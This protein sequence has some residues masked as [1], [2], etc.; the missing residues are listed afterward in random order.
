MMNDM[1]WEEDEDLDLDSFEEDEN[2]NGAPSSAIQIGQGLLFGGLSRLMEAVTQPDSSSLG[3]EEEDASEDGWNDD[4]LDE[5]V[6]DDDDGNDDVLIDGDSAVQEEEPARQPPIIQQQQQQ[7]IGGWD[8]DDGLDGL[9]E[10]SLHEESQIHTEEGWND[11]NDVLEGLEDSPVQEPHIVNPENIPAATVPSVAAAVPSPPPQDDSGGWDNDDESLEGLDDSLPV[12]DSAETGDE[13]AEGGWD[14]DALLEGLDDSPEKGPPLSPS[15]N[16]DDEGWGNDEDDLDALHDFQAVVDHVPTPPRTPSRRTESIMTNADESTVLRENARDDEEF[17]PSDADYGPIVD[18]LPTSEHAVAGTAAPSEMSLV[19]ESCVDTLQED[20][21]ENNAAKSSE[22]AANEVVDHV[23]EDLSNA[24]TSKDTDSTASVDGDEPSEMPMQETA[25][26]GNSTGTIG[27]SFG[28]V[29]D[30]MPSEQHFSHV[31][32]EHTTS[33]NVP[34]SLNESLEEESNIQEKEV[35]HVPDDILD[36]AEENDDSTASV[37]GDDTCDAREE[38]QRLEQ[39]RAFQRKILEVDHVPDDVSNVSFGNENS[40]ASVDGDAPSEFPDRT[41]STMAPSTING[42]LSVDLN[43]IKGDNAAQAV[44][45]GRRY[46]GLVDHVPEDSSKSTAR[47][48]ILAAATQMSVA[49]ELS[50]TLGDEALESDVDAQEEN[51]GPVVDHTPLNQSIHSRRNPSIRVQAPI[52]EMDEESVDEE[53]YFGP[54]VDHTPTVQASGVA[55][56]AGSM[57]VA[58]PPSEV[59]EDSDDDSGGPSNTGDQRQGGESDFC[60]DDT[61]DAPTASLVSVSR[62]GPALVD[63]VPNRPGTRPT[64][65][66]TLVVVD[67]SEVSTVGDMTY[68]EQQYGPVVDHLPPAQ[69]IAQ[70]SATGS[71]VNA[72]TGSVG[73]DDTLV[74]DMDD[75]ADEG[76]HHDENESDGD[77]G[78][79]LP[80]LDNPPPMEANVVDHVP[81]E[82]PR[83]F[84]IDSVLT[85]A[86]TQSVLSTDETR[87]S[88]FGLVVD[89][90]PMAL[91][92]PPSRGSM[93]VLVPESVLDADTESGMVEEEASTPAGEQPASER[94]T[95]EAKILVDHLPPAR[96]SV[97]MRSRDSTVTVRSHVSDDDTLEGIARPDR[98]GP[99][100]DQLPASGVSIQRSIGGSTT[101]ALATLSEVND[102]TIV[103]EDPHGWDDDEPELDSILDAENDRQPRARPSSRGLSVTFSHETLKTIQN[104]ADGSRDF[105][106]SIADETQYFD[107]EQGSTP[108]KMSETQ[109]S[110]YF[111]P[112]S[113]EMM[114]DVNCDSSLLINGDSKL[115]T[116]PKAKCASCD[117]ATGTECP[118][119]QRILRTNSVE[120]AIVLAVTTPEGV[121]VELD[122]KKLLQDETTKRLLLEKEL[123]ALKSTVESFETIVS[124]K[125]AASM[126]DKK[127]T[128]E[129]RETADTASRELGSLISERDALKRENEE[130]ASQLAASRNDSAIHER[131]RG[132]W[133]LREA[134]LQTEMEELRCSHEE[135]RSESQQLANMGDELASEVDQMRN[136]NEELLIQLDTQKRQYDALQ[137][138]NKG[139]VDEGASKER[140]L[141]D[142]AKEKSDLTNR[143]SALEDEI[144][145]LRRALEESSSAATSEADLRNQL[146]SL[147]IEA[148]K[149]SGECEELRSQ[150]EEF[151]KKLQESEGRGFAQMKE[152]TRLQRVHDAEIQ[153]LQDQIQSLQQSKEISINEHE[154]TVK[155]LQ[156]KVSQMMS[157]VQSL[158]SENESLNRTSNE[159]RIKYEDRLRQER[160]S[161]QVHVSQ[162]RALET[163]VKMLESAKAKVS[164]DL[165]SMSLQLQDSMEQLNASVALKEEH[166][167]LLQTLAV[168]KETI[169]SLQE[170]VEVLAQANKT[171]TDQMESLVQAV[172]NERDDLRTT[173]QSRETDLRSLQSQLDVRSN[174]KASLEQRIE[175]LAAKCGEMEAYVEELQT[176]VNRKELELAEKERMCESLRESQSRLDADAVSQVREQYDREVKNL[177]QLISEREENLRQVQYQLQEQMNA[178]RARDGTISELQKER[179][180]MQGQIAA[181]ASDRDSTLSR[182]QDLDAEL[183]RMKELLASLEESTA[184]S[185]RERELQASLDLLV[186]E[187]D[188]ALKERD[189][190]EEDNEE[191]LVQLGLMKEQVDANEGQIGEL[192][193]IV[194]EKEMAVKH[195]EN[196]LRDAER[197]IAELSRK[198]D[199][200]PQENGVHQPNVKLTELEETI[201]QLTLEKEDL[202]QQVDDLSSTNAYIDAQVT[203]LRDEKVELLSKLNDMGRREKTSGADASKKE[204][205]YLLRTRELEEQ[206]RRLEQ[207]CQQKD[208]ELVQ[209]RSLVQEARKASNESQADINSLSQQIAELQNACTEQGRALHDRDKALED[210]MLEMEGLRSQSSA[211]NAGSQ[212]NTETS[213]DDLLRQLRHAERSA[214]HYQERLREMEVILEEA[215]RE[216]KLKTERLSETEST[217]FDRE[218]ELDLQDQEKSAQ[219]DFQKQVHEMEILLNQRNQEIQDAFERE[220]AMKKTLY[221]LQTALETKGQAMS[222]GPNSNAV[223]ET[224]QLRAQLSALQQ[225]LASSTTHNSEREERARQ[226]V[227]SLNETIAKKKKQIE[228]L[229]A[230]LQ[231]LS[232]E[233]SSSQNQLVSKEADYRRLSI[234]LEE[235]RGDQLESTRTATLQV[236]ESSSKEQAE[237]VDTMRSHIITLAQALEQSETQ[238]ADAIERLL[239]ERKA[240]AD[241]LRRLGESVKRFYSSLSYRD[242]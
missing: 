201:E 95:E 32:A 33:T 94:T 167:S 218:L 232:A 187:R 183:A 42:G 158:K 238:R 174:E 53:E 69:S 23:P 190:L 241:S 151:Q 216:L 207:V 3:L 135:C 5:L 17:E 7:D 109:E 103:D 120:D 131:A 175:T 193:Q 168:N 40:T 224:H 212:Q 138:E 12:Q 77:D 166:D 59:D 76:R 54:V 181:L 19:S 9:E 63:H 217:L 177:T 85:T 128:D 124:R 101:G 107:T 127:I 115:A 173:L 92:S 102:D 205:Q 37:D 203:S 197:Y 114:G 73:P 66:S 159:T 41:I 111:D 240:N 198:K 57:A 140:M 35:D 122:V 30:R 34:S 209:A 126:E 96:E 237:S 46:P 160:N 163:K 49:S 93:A 130:L 16:D 29:V 64:D 230:Q 31:A 38:D 213:V 28:R 44:A 86:P 134:A 188:A 179:A 98:F 222:N 189:M 141:S 36:V 202:Q 228:S 191:L 6:D 132:E 1:G 206:C 148:A 78:A 27:N 45:S 182:C 20:G 164:E 146:S 186:S 56:I 145:Q 152:S 157:Q 211:A 208:E 147:Q 74:G 99:V 108:A 185:E 195:A 8:D 81:E 116:S 215:R 18:H 192:Q 170:Q 15:S 21:T 142:M 233:F 100:V 235:T 83:S 196:R 14:D 117:E 4:G 178:L 156:D 137:A 161:S 48:S 11:D 219:I 58:A 136:A 61:L 90:L 236:L 150:V 125:E 220:Q 50:N 223:E 68:E 97:S 91:P 154:E 79:T 226:E 13:A 214:Q 155:I 234:E 123:E 104:L 113:G 55:S 210:M 24:P 87:D 71:T 129:L 52:E 139:L 171:G 172:S 144:L 118:C 119:I 162:S 169:Q 84:R 110:Q 229:E 227:I 106:T 65:A 75:V 43:V 149:Q 89:H 221:E 88:E 225:Q 60:D 70:A 39:T 51:Y 143:K 200:T 26:R 133:S 25:L 204:K 165:A 231:S 72:A 180:E 2:G 184:S 239:K 121:H 112:E 47:A 199:E 176:N 194:A 242:A 80:T 67:P 105:F 153:R 82:G 10:M 62:Y 22:H